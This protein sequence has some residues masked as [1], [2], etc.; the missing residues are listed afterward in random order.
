MKE[1]GAEVTCSC[2]EYLGYIGEDEEVE[3]PLCGEICDAEGVVDR[4]KRGR[5]E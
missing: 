3:C 4:L 2:G 1:R 5:D